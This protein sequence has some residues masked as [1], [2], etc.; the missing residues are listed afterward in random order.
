MI[1]KKSWQEFRETGLLLLV[2][3]FLHIFGWALVVDVEK[4]EEG[5]FVR[6]NSCYPARTGFRGFSAKS[7]SEAYEKISRYMVDNA[8]ELYEEASDNG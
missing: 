5:K 7:T 8:A 1:E 4:D 3:Q 6:V 2:N